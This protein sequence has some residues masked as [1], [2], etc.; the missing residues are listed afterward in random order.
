MTPAYW[1]RLLFVG[2]ICGSLL[3]ACLLVSSSAYWCDFLLIS[4]IIWVA[5]VVT[6]WFDLWVVAV[7]AAWPITK[8]THTHTQEFPLLLLDLIFSL[9]V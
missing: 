6:G 8:H 4:L 3:D 1:F 7:V 9:L 5:A 2:L